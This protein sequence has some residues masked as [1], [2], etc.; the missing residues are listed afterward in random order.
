MVSKKLKHEIPIHCGDH[1]YIK[2]TYFVT[3]PDFIG[4]SNKRSTKQIDN[5]KHLK[6]NNNNGV[7]SS[8]SLSRLRSSINWLCTSAKYKPVWCKQS[9]KSFYFKTNFITLTIP[10]QT[11]FSEYC[12][13]LKFDTKYINPFHTLLKSTVPVNYL[14]SV[15][16]V[17]FTKCLNTFLT[18]SRKHPSIKLHNYVWKL[19][20]S[21]DGRLHVHFSTDIFYH[22]QHLRDAW[23]RI[24][25]REGLLNQHFKK[26]NNYNPNSTDVH[27]VHKVRDVASY[28]CEYMTKKP[29]LTKDFKGRI[30]SASYSLSNKNKCYTYLERGSDRRNFT[31]VDR[32]M[33][34]YKRIESKPDCM[35]VKKTVASLYML[36]EKQWNTDMDGLI[37]EAYNTHRQRIRD[38]TPLQPSEYLT[39]DFFGHYSKPNYEFINLAEQQNTTCEIE[40]STQR[41]GLIQLDLQF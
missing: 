38:N 26:F 20:A 24:L 15:K 18:Y 8:K 33:I 12:I 6:N 19:E 32:P 2:P 9:R 41:N 28:M 35:G 5:Q 16:H 22:Y 31:F 40:K 25:Q 11:T 1:V 23:N 37:K 17:Q 21:Q 10:P 27:S 36:N 39:I 13:L 3:K 7:L 30:W 34:K 29:N 4:S 14:P